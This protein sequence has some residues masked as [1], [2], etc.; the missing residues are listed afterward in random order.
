[1][2]PI[3]NLLILN[4]MKKVLAKSDI[5]IVHFLP[6][7]IR[8]KC[9]AWKGTASKSSLILERLKNEPKVNSA[10]LSTETGTLLIEFD[11]GVLKNLSLLEN[12]I[13]Q[14]EDVMGTK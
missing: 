1:M 7:R 6:G 2:L 12:W 8:L 14:V 13:V 3:T 5:E 4:K 10:K 9:P 11:Q